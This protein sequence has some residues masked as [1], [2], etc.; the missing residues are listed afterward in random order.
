MSPFK[1]AG[2]QARWRSLYERL[3]RVTVGDVLTYE[4]MAEL[5]QLNPVGDRH[6]MQMAMRRAARELEQ[7]NK[8]AV[9]ALPNIGY[10]VVEPAGHVILAKHHQGKAGR[11][12]ERS[13]SKV[14]NVDLNATSPEL[15]HI[16]EIG[17]AAIAAQ[18]DFNRRMDLRQS[19]L[20]QAVQ[21]VASKTNRTDEELAELRERL[22]RLEQRRASEST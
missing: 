18:M 22:A 10:R 11:S 8:H 20:E 7:V 2:K 3:C 9:A 16:I 14:I 19:N 5:L 4:E 15:R 12:L 21:A 6:V 1:P 17:A 13:H